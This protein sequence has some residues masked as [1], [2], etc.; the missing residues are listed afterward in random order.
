MKYNGKE[1]VPITTTDVQ[2]L[3]KRML[4]WDT[5]SNNAEERVVIA[6]VKD[7]FD[8]IYVIA[9][10]ESASGIAIWEYCAEFPSVRNATNRELAEWLAKGNGEVRT[11][12]QYV[13]T[14]WNYV[15]SDA[16]KIITSLIFVKKF[17]D[18]DWHKP[19][20]EYLDLVQK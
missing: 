11:N 17:E 3:P 7:K 13:Y 15:S 18:D 1:L 19:T 8:K 14:H 12:G 16:N 2:C 20:A 4:V 9:Q 10:H 5:L 6:L